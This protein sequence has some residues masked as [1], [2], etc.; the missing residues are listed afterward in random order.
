MSMQVFLYKISDYHEEKISELI[1]KILDLSF[2]A[3]TLSG[4][5]V[6]VKPNLLTRKSP[7]RAVTTHPFIIKE[8][9]SYFRNKGATVLIGDSPGGPNS[10]AWLKS[11]YQISGM[12]WAAREAGVELNYDL[13]AKEIDLNFKGTTKSIQLMKQVVDSDIIIN[14][15]KFKTHGLTVI[16]GGPKNLYGCVPGLIKAQ[17]HL[18]LAQL[19]SFCELL[20]S[21][22]DF[23]KPELTILDAIL[24]MEGDGPSG[25]TPKHMGYLL[26]SKDCFAID[27]VASNIIGLN[28]KNIPIL[29]IAERKKIISLEKDAI[30]I[31]GDKDYE[32][33][34]FIMPITTKHADFSDK[35]A[36]VIPENLLKGIYGYLKPTVHFSKEKCTTCNICIKSCPVGALRMESDV[37]S[38]DKNECIYCY[39]CQE[40]CPNDAVILRKS[41]IF[42]R[43][44][45]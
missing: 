39:C 16:T 35:F 20:V 18:E 26:A 45:G 29:K 31:I 22:A 28:P 15:P 37:P 42:K 1:K 33:I 36:K 27:V 25:G 14:V 6:F 2:A 44:F 43:L 17:Y 38:V 4:K 30:E 8:I 32:I 11:I 9:C 13:T 24:A 3:K 12:S 23:L 21:I 40:I 19:E 7:D 41:T 10:H 34:P 5:R